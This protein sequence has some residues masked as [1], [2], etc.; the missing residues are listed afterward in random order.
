MIKRVFLWLLIVMAVISGRAIA[1]DQEKEQ[2][3]V[4]IA[5]AW[6]QLV[7]NGNYAQGWLEAASYFKE[8]VSESQMEEAFKIARK[9]FG[10]IVTRQVKNSQYMTS[11]PGGPEGEYFVIQF[12]A[13]FEN[14]N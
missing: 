1:S 5:E 11:V 10:K 12:N 6:L 13:T 9:P 3:A 2:K 4:K 7:D 8:A 14:K